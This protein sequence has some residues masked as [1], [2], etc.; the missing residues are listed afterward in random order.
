MDKFQD[1][2]KT[3]FNERKAEYQKKKDSYDR[4][5]Q[6]S[7]QEYDRDRKFVGNLSFLPL[8]TSFS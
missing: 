1:E 2:L 8:E 5:N 3:E 6:Q 4:E 7:Q